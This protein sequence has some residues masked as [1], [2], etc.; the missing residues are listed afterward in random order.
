MYTETYQ[1]NPRNALKIW[2]NSKETLTSERQLSNASFHTSHSVNSEEAKEPVAFQV[3]KCERNPNILESPV[4]NKPAPLPPATA[5]FPT[6]ITQIQKQQ[7]CNMNKADNRLMNVNPQMYSHDP[8]QLPPQVSGAT[9]SFHSSISNY[10]YTV[11]QQRSLDTSHLAHT[12]H[13]SRV[14]TQ[15]VHQLPPTDNQGRPERIHAKTN[16]QLPPRPQHFPNIPLHNLPP[17]PIP[18][19]L[20]N[21][22]SSQQQKLHEVPQLMKF[23]PQQNLSHY[24]EQTDPNKKLSS[25]H[26]R[27]TTYYHDAPNAQPTSAGNLGGQPAERTKDTCGNKS[28]NV[29]STSAL[30][31]SVSA[32][33]YSALLQY[34]QNYQE[35]MSV[36]NEGGTTMKSPPK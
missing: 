27:S 22:T 34:I 8:K 36:S 33:D 3:E 6:N 16:H 32:P 9:A 13:P 35:Q 5:G 15:I 19:H 2:G 26:P 28:G 31:S 24:V 14:Q 10:N 18:P 20:Q 12:S 4:M 23:Q 1:N 29:P 17:P 25:A 11:N 7:E 30:G 21:V